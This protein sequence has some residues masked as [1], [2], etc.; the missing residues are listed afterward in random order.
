MGIR[1]LGRGRWFDGRLLLS[2]LALLFGA[3]LG[4][5]VGGLTVRAITDPLPLPKNEATVALIFFLLS[6]LLL[7]LTIEGKDSWVLERQ[8]QRQPKLAMRSKQLNLLVWGI[9][10]GNGFTTMVRQGSFFLVVAL[11]VFSSFKGAALLG[12]AF[13]VTRVLRTSRALNPR[14]PLDHAVVCFSYDSRL[15]KQF[16]LAVLA[17]ALVISLVAVVSALTR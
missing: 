6:I 3:T 17:T 4:G 12:G 10:L 11:E 14:L 1:V 13:A 7:V 16:E 9:D 2:F 15:A 5:A 8:V